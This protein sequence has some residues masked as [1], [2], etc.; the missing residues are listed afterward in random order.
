MGEQ[1]VAGHD[2]RAP[3]K[4]ILDVKVGQVRRAKQHAIRLHNTYGYI[5]ITQIFHVAGGTIW[6]LHPLSGAAMSAE[7]EDE[8]LCDRCGRRISDSWG[9]L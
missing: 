8:R 3:H 1:C 2:L 9:R 7:W 5:S 6:P 4:Y